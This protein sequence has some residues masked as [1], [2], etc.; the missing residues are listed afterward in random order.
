MRGKRNAI[1]S[2]GNGLYKGV[3]YRYV[4][5]VDCDEYGWCYVGNTTDEKHRRYSWN[6]HGNKNYGGRKIN[7]A[8]KRYGLENFEYEV[9]ERV[10]AS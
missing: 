6:N 7:D 10:E 4:N 3:V 9:L 8:R 5:N 2:N 1:T